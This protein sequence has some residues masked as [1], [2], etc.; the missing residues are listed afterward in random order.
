VPQTAAFTHAVT[1]SDNNTLMQKL[2]STD[3]VQGGQYRVNIR[4]LPDN[5]IVT[6]SG[7]NENCTDEAEIK[8]DEPQDPFEEHDG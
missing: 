3:L 7:E 2:E 5:I 6:L 4:V 8:G 1:T